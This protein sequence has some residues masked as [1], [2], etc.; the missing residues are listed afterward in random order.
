MPLEITIRG[1]PDDVYARL[2]AEAALQEKSFED[3]LHVELQRIAQQLPAGEILEEVRKSK[4]REPA[5]VPSELI[6]KLLNEDRK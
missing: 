2:T 1:V 4:E 6:L 5:R 3:Y